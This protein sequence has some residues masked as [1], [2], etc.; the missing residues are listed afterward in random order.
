LV[1]ST[2]YVFYSKTIGGSGVPDSF[3]AK[4]LLAT[5]ILCFILGIALAIGLEMAL[6]ESANGKFSE[7]DRVKRAGKSWLTVGLLLSFLVTINYTAAKK[8]QIS[9]WS[10]LKAT[11]PSDSTKSMVSGLIEE[12]KITVFY[13][14]ENPVLGFVSDYFT[15]VG[16][17][18]STV[19]VSFLDKD[20]EPGTAERLKVSKNGI[21]VLEIGKQREKIN[22]GTT[23]R[24]A[25][26]NLSKLDGKFQKAFLGLSAKD[27]VAYF[28]SGHGELTWGGGE[29]NPLKK[30]TYVEA[31][32]RNQNYKIKKLDIM[33]GLAKDIPEDASVVII[34]G[35]TRAFAQEEV[36]VIEDYVENGGRTMILVDI[37]GDTTEGSDIAIA[38]SSSRP[39]YEFLTRTGIEFNP[40]PMANVSNYLRGT[41]TKLDHWF[42]FSNSFTSHESVSG[43]TKNDEKVAVFSIRS[44]SF[45]INT[46]HGKW[47]AFE[48]VRSLSGSFRDENKDYQYND[49]KEVKK[50]Y[51]I[52]AGAKIKSVSD[53]KSEGRIIAFADATVISDGVLRNPGNLLYLAGSLN[54][55]IGKADSVVIA[56]SEADVKIQHSKKED[57]L[58]FYGSVFFVPF[59]VLLTG[60]FVNRKKVTVVT[61]ENTDAA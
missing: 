3:M 57:N 58:V 14:K 61:K 41:K 33:S 47:S 50:S 25:R 48:T 46:R 21:V 23:I 16:K 10:Y 42:L 35:P 2:V 18:S 13:P 54:W 1:G 32:L 20:F 30:I 8:D 39:L 49:G 17:L 37:D 6:S 53:P 60:A 7:P 36:G 12:L 5:W 52:G 27:K 28:T 38:G 44:G 19:K 15:G 34:A 24:S 55:L 43:L 45:K 11:E 9:D 51:P 22:I 29:K 31:W 59:L 4:A 26:K 56:T 40:T